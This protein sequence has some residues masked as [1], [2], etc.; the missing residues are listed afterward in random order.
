[1]KS[2]LH[3][4]IGH[5]LQ[6]VYLRFN[7]TLEEAIVHNHSVVAAC[8]HFVYQWIIDKLTAVQVIDLIHYTLRLYGTH[9]DTQCKGRRHLDYAECVE[10][11]LAR[12]FAKVFHKIM[13]TVGFH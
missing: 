13:I 6:I 5:V 10:Y 8:Q 7:G 9:N 3:K 1:M 11:I 12:N 2:G 4:S